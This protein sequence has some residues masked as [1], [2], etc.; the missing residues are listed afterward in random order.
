MI[1]ELIKSTKEASAELLKLNE[2]RVNEVLVKVADALE[3]GTDKILHANAIDMEKLAADNPKRDRLL[4]TPAR[5]SSMASDMRKVAELPSPKR[6]IDR[7]VRPNGLEITRVAVPFGVVGQIYEARPNVTADVFSLCFKSGN[8]VVLRGGHEAES[9]NEAIVGIIHDVLKDMGI[10]PAV[11]TLLPSSREAGTELM[12]ARGLVDVI[13]P[14][15]SRGLIDSVRAQSTVPVIETGA[16]VCHTYIDKTADISM[17]A[18]IIN[19]GKTRRVSVCNS[20][21]CMVVH[22]DLLNDLSLICAPLALHDVTIYA[23][24]R[25]YQVLKG[26]YP[27]EFLFHATEE[28]F[29]REFLSYAMAVKTVD[30][31]AEALTHIA[32]YGSGHSEAIVTEDATS[33]DTFCREVDAAC[34]YV[35]APTSFTDGGQFGLGA[36]IGISTQKLHA[37]GP[38]GLEELMTYKWII[39]GDGQVRE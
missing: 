38:M 12:T 33:A 32:A 16:G 20:L 9:S 36:E 27:D 17:S 37:R 13:I 34:V 26:H 19:N 4:L 21:D 2:E 15:G 35:N 31:I 8:A 24:D 18:A 25:A 22:S 10:N 28:D 29:G 23:D 14:R 39:R 30:N 3:A 5:I 11:V 6:I 7:R 1:K